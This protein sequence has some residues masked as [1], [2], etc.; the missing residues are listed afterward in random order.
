MIG[1]RTIFA[2]SVAALFVLCLSSATFAQGTEYSLKG[3]VVSVDFLAQKLTIQSIDKI[4]S[5]ISGALGEYTFSMDKIT[6]VTMCNQNMP[7][8]DIKAGQE[9]TVS[10]RD[11]DGQLY[12]DSVAVSPP[13]IACLSE[14]NS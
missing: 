1:L 6:R 3:K 12:A 5:L 14:G 13:L 2:A 11:R 4:P 10:Y 9:V 7:I 8:K